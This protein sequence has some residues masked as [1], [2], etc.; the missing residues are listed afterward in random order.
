MS[1]RVI[2]DVLVWLAESVYPEP[3]GVAEVLEAY[4]EVLTERGYKIVPSESTAGPFL[5]GPEKR[6]C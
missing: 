2:D 5:P 1:K 3:W 4:H 6:G